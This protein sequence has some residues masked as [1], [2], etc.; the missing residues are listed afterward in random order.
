VKEEWGDGARGRGGFQ[1]GE[2]D[3]EKDGLKPWVGSGVTNR[4]GAAFL[5]SWRTFSGMLLCSRLSRLQGV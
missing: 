4:W 2:K 1:K 3:D 5:I